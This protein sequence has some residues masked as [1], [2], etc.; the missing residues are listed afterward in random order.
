MLCTHRM[1]ES[2]VE[3]REAILELY[4]FDRISRS[5]LVDV[6]DSSQSVREI[7]ATPQRLSICVSS[8]RW[9]EV[10]G[11]R[12]QRISPVTAGIVH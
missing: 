1:F 11:R 2:A 7:S 6:R 9:L 12:Q 3:S 5:R 4:G 10:N 8:A